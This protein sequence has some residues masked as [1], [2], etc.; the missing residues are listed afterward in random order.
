MIDFTRGPDEAAMLC[1]VCPEA[2]ELVETL[3]AHLR[4]YNA[5]RIAQVSALRRV[6]GLKCTAYDAS[7]PSHAELLRLARAHTRLLEGLGVGQFLFKK[8]LS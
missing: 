6:H 1:A 3:G 2:E 8:E 5:S 7:Q 4:R